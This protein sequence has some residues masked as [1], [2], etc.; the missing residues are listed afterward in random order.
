VSESSHHPACT[1]I[2]WAVIITVLV[3]IGTLIYDAG[4]GK[5]YHNTRLSAIRTDPRHLA[6]AQESSL[7]EAALT[8][9]TCPR[10]ISGPPM[11][12]NSRSE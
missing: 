10:S 11:E 8:L 5:A 6:E 12:W 4:M 7:E 2:A 9:P 1:A 3:A